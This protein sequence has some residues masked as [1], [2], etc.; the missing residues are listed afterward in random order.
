MFVADVNPGTPL[1]T[2]KVDRLNVEVHLT[3]AATGIAAATACRARI[4]EVV[5]RHDTCRMIF[6]AAPSQNE[7]LAQLRASPDIP[8]HRVEA[9]H[10][11]EY[12]GLP[13]GAPE[14]FSQFLRRALFDHVPLQATHLLDAAG[15]PIAEEMSRYAALLRAAPIDVV[16]LGVGENG[17]I[18][19]N[20]PPAD[21]H[22][23]LLIKEVEL[24]RACR[25]QQVHDGAFA[26]LDA[27]PERA[28]TLTVPALMRG[29]SLFCVV[30]GRTKAVA[31]MTMLTRP[32]AESCPAS[33]LRTHPDC[34]LYLDSDSASMWL[35]AL[36]AARSCGRASQP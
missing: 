35:G 7:L 23:P 14:R 22:D 36:S 31:V 3:R 34:T 26:S 17:H 18:A 1:R 20:D 33:I 13:P 30:P 15:L 32:V 28:I 2:M 21:F 6:A 27:V 29:R 8:W 9:F 25:Q 5:A 10:M 12:R 11:D 19:F 16:C 24:D 4:G